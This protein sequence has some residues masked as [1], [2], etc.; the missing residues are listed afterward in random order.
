V[1]SG[2]AAGVK[3]NVYIILVRHQNGVSRYNVKL[4]LKDIEVER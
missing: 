4:D 1:L 3:A 2:N